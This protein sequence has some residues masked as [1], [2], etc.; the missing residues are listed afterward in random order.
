MIGLAGG[1][2]KLQTEVIMAVAADLVSPATA[3][4]ECSLKSGHLTQGEGQP[5]DRQF[6]EARPKLK[7]ALYVFTTIVL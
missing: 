3:G 5:N 6:I 2:H 4:K 7:A 1:K